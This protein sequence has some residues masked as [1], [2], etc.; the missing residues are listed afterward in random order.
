MQLACFIYVKRN[1][2]VDRGRL[3][4]IL[5]YF[6][7]LSYNYSLLIFPEGTDLTPQTVIRSD[8]FAQKNNLPVSN[9]PRGQQHGSNRNVLGVRIRASSQDHRFRIPCPALD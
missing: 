8:E 9:Q 6:C 1:W 5:D 2:S 4:K 3:K 7:S